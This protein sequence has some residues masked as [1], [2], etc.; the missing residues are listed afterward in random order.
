ME[1]VSTLTE[2]LRNKLIIEFKQLKEK[3]YINCEFD[4]END[5]DINDDE[6]EFDVE[7]DN[8]YA[9]E[10]DNN[11]LDSTFDE[12][13]DEELNNFQKNVYL[14]LSKF[15]KDNKYKNIFYLIILK[16]V[17]ECIK[18]KVLINVKVQDEEYEIL[19]KLEDH[20]LEDLLRKINESEAF[21]LNLLTIFFIYN[22]DYTIID[23]Y[24]NRKIIEKSNNKQYLDKFK[25]SFLDDI[26]YQ[27]IKTRK[28][29]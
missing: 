3:L 15:I 18:T 7:F 26:Q 17:Y 6:D 9:V 22:D 28:T 12:Y 29:H 19:E 24:K 11:E 16:D 8:D 10:I 14:N 27:Y 4:D 1:I 25:I 2:E 5:F 13:K 23:K 20:D 21:F